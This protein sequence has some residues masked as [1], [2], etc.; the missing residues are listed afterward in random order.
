MNN[1]NV[2]ASKQQIRDLV[3]DFFV[4]SHDFNGISLRD[5]GEQLNIDYEVSIDLVIQLAEEKAVSIQS[6]TN[7][8]II[9]FTHYSVQ[10]QR[11]ILEDAKQINCTHTEF[12]GFT[13]VTENTEFPICVYPA[14]EYLERHRDLRPFG[15]AVFSK[16]LAM[17]DPQLRFIFFDLDVLDRYSGDP[18]YVFKFD[19]Y[20]GSIHC[21]YENDQP[22]VREEDEIFLKSFGLGYDSSGNRLAAVTLGYLKNLSPEH[23]VYWMGKEFKGKAKILKEYY[24]NIIEGNW[25]FTHSIFSGFIGEQNCVNE[26]TEIIF[27][28]RLFLKSFKTEERP[29]EFTLFFK[30]TLKNYNEFIMLLDKMISDNINK[31]FFKG[32][33]ELEELIPIEG[34]LVERRQKGT[35]RIFE[36]WLLAKYKN[37]DEGIDW[38]FKVFKR[39]RKERQDPA[40]KISSDEYDKAYDEKQKLVM[41][42]VYKAM[43]NLRY[44]FADHRLA[45]EFKVPR[46][47]A[48]EQITPF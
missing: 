43:L 10:D 24:E 9:G 19:D 25:V 12:G 40:H 44:A 34:N 22:V 28:K 47:L 41:V 8:H 37:A 38:I 1:F 45:A 26:L 35:L 7:P 14:P 20:S 46:W 31:D 33:I 32:T 21:K 48:E 42:D 27:G 23:Q 36:E 2:E 5:I 39:V 29:R 30:P 6:S 4:Q 13:V 18:R 17:G 3:F 15:N 16:R 11:R